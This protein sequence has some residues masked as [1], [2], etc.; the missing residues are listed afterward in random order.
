MLADLNGNNQPTEDELDFII[1]VSDKKPPSGELGKK[2]F[3][4]A[5]NAWEM[6][7]SDFAD[8][9]CWGSEVFK[10]YDTDKSGKLSPGQLHKFLVEYNDGE[11]VSD[12]DCEWV[13][14]KADVL[15]DGQVTKMEVSMALGF[16]Y[17]KRNQKKA[18]EA[19]KSAVCS[20]L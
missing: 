8:E 19:A 2:E 20:I 16:W 18:E 9:T 6:Y 13:L 12:I 14:S 1:K 17:Q 15:G 7:L 3:V 11:E 10:K 4:E 5:R